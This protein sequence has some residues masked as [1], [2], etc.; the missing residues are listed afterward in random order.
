MY[1]V[2]RRL[3][4]QSPD[5]AIVNGRMLLQIP[6]DGNGGSGALYGTMQVQI[7]SC[8]A[9]F[10]MCDLIVEA[11]IQADGILKLHNTIQTRQIIK[12]EGV[13]PQRDGFEP[14]FRGAREVDVFLHGPPDEPGVLR[15]R[16]SSEVGG[17]VYSRATG[18]WSR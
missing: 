14:E 6:P 12:L 13:P 2:Y 3:P 16:F 7:G 10:E 8:Y 18:K 1:E 15:G 17:S 5:Y 11:K 4:L 9:E